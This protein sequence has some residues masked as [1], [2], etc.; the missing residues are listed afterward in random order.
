MSYKNEETDLGEELT[1]KDVIDIIGNAI[2]L[3]G[4]G[5]IV[6]TMYR[7]ITRGYA[8]YIEHNPYISI[9]EFIIGIGGVSYFIYKLYK[10]ASNKD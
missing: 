5:L 9:S 1:K 8:H 6:F 7:I 4:S 10:I 3:V 2:G